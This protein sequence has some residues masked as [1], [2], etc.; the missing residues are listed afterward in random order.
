V[1]PDSPI[2]TILNR[3]EIEVAADLSIIAG[4]TEGKGF[5][6]RIREFVTDNMFDEPNDQLVNTSS[7]YGGVRRTR[8]PDDLLIKGQVNHFSYFKSRKCREQLVRWLLDVKPP[9]FD[10]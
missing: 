9:A 1:D 3:Q 4:D 10:D 5:W 6:G 8:D 7:M 2:V